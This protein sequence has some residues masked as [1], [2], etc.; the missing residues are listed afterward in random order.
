ME[1]DVMHREWGTFN[2]K[3]WFVLNVK[4]SQNV[5]LVFWRLCSNHSALKLDANADNYCYITIKLAA[6]IYEMKRNLLRHPCTSTPATFWCTFETHFKAQVLML[7]STDVLWRAAKGVQEI[8]SRSPRGWTSYCR[9]SS[10]T[11]LKGG[12][13]SNKWPMCCD[14]WK[15]TPSFIRVQGQRIVESIP[16]NTGREAYRLSGGEFAF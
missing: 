5:K 13:T 3:V 10:V 4:C 11:E 9:A 7:V 14:K 6:Y 12:Y 15:I 2:G 1:R 8:W 16:L